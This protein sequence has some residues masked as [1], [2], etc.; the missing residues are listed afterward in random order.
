MAEQHAR[1][2]DLSRDVDWLRVSVIDCLP[3]ASQAVVDDLQGLVG[4]EHVD[5]AVRSSALLWKVNRHIAKRNLAT[6]PDTV[7]PA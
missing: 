1:S 6:A 7:S 2:A 4:V 3:R 5:L